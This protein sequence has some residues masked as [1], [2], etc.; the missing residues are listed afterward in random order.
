[1]EKLRVITVV[2]VLVAAAVLGAA[3]AGS[4]GSKGSKQQTILCNMTQD[5]LMECKPAVTKGAPPVDPTPAC[6]A[7]LGTA[8]LSCLCGY[9]HSLF[10]PS[11]GIDPELAMKLPEKCSLVSPAECQG[12]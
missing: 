10:L 3:D 11:L 6:C 8:D 7:A 1:M 9:K 12:N 5:G 4:K 2:V